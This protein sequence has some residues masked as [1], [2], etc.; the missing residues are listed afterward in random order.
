[1]SLWTKRI[2]LL[3]LPDDEHALGTAIQER[4]PAVQFVDNRAWESPEV[5]PVRA[6]ILDCDRVAAIWNPEITP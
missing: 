2:E 5:P 4:F 6:S 3:L 1:M